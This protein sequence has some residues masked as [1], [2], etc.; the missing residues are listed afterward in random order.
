MG[1]DFLENNIVIGNYEYFCLLMVLLLIFLLILIKITR[2]NYFWKRNASDLTADFVESVNKNNIPQFEKKYQNLFYPEIWFNDC[3]KSSAILKIKNEIS[4]RYNNLNFK[5]FE[6]KRNLVFID[7]AGKTHNISV[8]DNFII[9]EDPYINKFKFNL[10]RKNNFP[11]LWPSSLKKF[12]KINFDAKYIDNFEF[13]NE[14]FYYTH[15]YDKSENENSFFNNRKPQDFVY[16]LMEIPY[17]NKKRK[18]VNEIFILD[19][20]IGININKKLIQKHQIQY[21]LSHY[22]EYLTSIS[23]EL[24]SISKTVKKEGI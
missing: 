20:F 2:I 9:I 12:Y 7:V 23:D 13:N 4:G 8:R 15:S 1:K 5:I 21:P 14:E 22:L 3:L 19:N 18:V 17:S 6:I 16:D 11:D 10:I 24:T